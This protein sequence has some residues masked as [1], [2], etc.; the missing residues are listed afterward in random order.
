MDEPVLGPVGVAL[1]GCGRI[2][3][4]H[5]AAAAAVP[6]AVRIVATVDPDPASA[7]A[8]ASR[9]ASSLAAVIIASPS[10]A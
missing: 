8:A 3:G 6:E 7:Q 1:I 10:P 2:S 5:L 4:M 9:K